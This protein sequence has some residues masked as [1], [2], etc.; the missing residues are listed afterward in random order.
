MEP[1][2]VIPI[3]RAWADALLDAALELP[4]EERD[5]FLESRCASHPD[6]KT[7]VLQLLTA[8]DTP[9]PILDGCVARLLP[10]VIDAGD[11]GSNE[12]SAGDAIGPWRIVRQIGRGGMGT[13]FLV[14]RNDGQFA[15]TAAL[16]LL[17]VGLDSEEITRRFERERQIVAS[18]THA[19]I[20]RLLDGGRTP[21]GLPY[22][23]MECVEG[24]AIDRD[25]DERRLT[26]DQ[27]L[28]TFEQVCGAV[29]YAHAQLVVH[30][31]VK[32]SNILVTQDGEV[33]LLDFGI[34]RI[35]EPPREGSA[36]ATGPIA[37]I[38]TP[39]Y[40]SPEQVRGDPVAT[41][42]DVYQLGLLLYELLTGDRA[43]RVQGQ[44][45]RDLERAICEETPLRPS[46]RA[47]SAT[48]TVCE[49]RR[50]GRGALVRKLHG[51]LDTIVMVALRKEADRRYRSVADLR[52]DVRRYARGLPVRARGDRLP[53]RARKF[54]GRHRV[55]LGFAAA[56]LLT[57]LIVTPMVAAQRMRATQEQQR[58]RQMEEVLE[59][60]FALP[61]PHFPPGPSSTAEFVEHATVIV[62]SELR[63]QPASEARLLNVLGRVYIWL[64]RYDDSLALLQE[65]LLIRER[66]FGPD[67]SEV[68]DSCDWLAQTLHY[69]GRYAD[70]ER[71]LRRAAAIRRNRLGP[72]ATQTLETALE[73]G[74][75][76]HSRGELAAADDIVRD[77]L[78]RLR[79]TG[80]HGDLL[81]RGLQY[82]GNIL[83]DEGRLD[84]SAAAFREAIGVYRSLS[85][86]L[87]P[88][89]AIAEL[90]YGRVLIRQRNYAEAERRLL[91][92]QHDI[93]T[94]YGGDHPVT[95]TALRELGYLRTEQG[96]YDEALRLLEESRRLALA[97]LGPGHPQIARTAVHQA[98]AERRRGHA[99]AAVSIAEEALDLFAQLDLSE[100]PS[101]IDARITLGQALLALGHSDRARIELQAAYAA[102]SRKFVGGDDR[103]ARARAALDAASVP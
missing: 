35:L 72:N 79:A 58:A 26:I 16:K 36:D 7:E 43:Q 64:G 102:A 73:L 27:R 70:A 68:A 18:L 14:E 95:V 76:L 96:R 101:A 87:N 46:D 45:S 4:P 9:A 98:E 39:D 92:A 6:L 41:S 42:S 55:A 34:A 25:C 88:Q 49:V 66:E 61:N 10:E 19:S 82:H 63:G 47:R 59:R 62:R 48:D 84:E 23:V 17:R 22:F 100:H 37:T 20:A 52:D 93:R 81:G 74:D 94:I 1:A 69:R 40:A 29:Q 80:T 11:D 53:Y 75:L 65:G 31:D 44:S 5:A 28:A 77:A 12:P 67:S 32:P 2:P 54:A 15:Q 83:R 60:L 85:G 24:R 57:I 91:S 30:R 86:Q 99:A 97:L 103:I 90:Y 3:R 78:G 13:V 51:D 33:K 38:L 89:A 21:G 50:V 56:L 71:M 8:H